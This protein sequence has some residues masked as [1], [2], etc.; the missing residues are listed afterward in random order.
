MLSEQAVITFDVFRHK[1]NEIAYSIKVQVFDFFC[2]DCL[3]VNIGIDDDDV[4]WYVVTTIAT[5]DQV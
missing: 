3:I 2:N 4:G 5:I 1:A